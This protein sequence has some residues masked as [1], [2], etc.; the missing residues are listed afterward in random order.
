MWKKTI[1]AI[2]IGVLAVSLWAVPTAG[3]DVATGTTT[4]SHATIGS[5]G[6][7]S[8]TATGWT[9]CG[10]RCVPGWWSGY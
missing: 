2:V 1:T 10:G 8:T 9:G 4:V 3:A 6:I 7:G 5:A